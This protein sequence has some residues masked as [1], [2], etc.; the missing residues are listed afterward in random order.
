MA[1]SSAKS[2][3]WSVIASATSISNSKRI[4]AHEKKGNNPKFDLRKGLF[5]M[6]GTDLTRIDSIDVMTATT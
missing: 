1:I 5:R 6:T 2:R 4:A 3:W